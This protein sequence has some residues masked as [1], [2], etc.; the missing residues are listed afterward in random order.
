[1]TWLVWFPMST[2]RGW[3]SFLPQLLPLYQGMRIQSAS[4][5]TKR[6]GPILGF[7][8][9]GVQFFANPSTQWSRDY[10]S[11]TVIWSSGIAQWSFEFCRLRIFILL[12]SSEDENFLSRWGPGEFSKNFT[13]VR[14]L[15]KEGRGVVYKSMVEL[16]NAGPTCCYFSNTICLPALS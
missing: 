2:R 11:P 4:W 9:D 10:S 16:L 8:G 14:V 6:K 7:R 15:A 12:R 3:P 5:L 1:M 13:L